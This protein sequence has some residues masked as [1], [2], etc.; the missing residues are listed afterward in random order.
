MVKANLST[1]QS[2]ECK[3]SILLVRNIWKPHK[4]SS[5]HLY[6]SLLQSVNSKGANMKVH[7]ITKLNNPSDIW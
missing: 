2:Q 7:P 6:L 5:D 3:G 1:R 4:T